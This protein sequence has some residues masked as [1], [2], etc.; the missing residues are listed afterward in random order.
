VG[1]R[2]KQRLTDYVDEVGT[3]GT[4]AALP[5]LYA[6]GERVGADASGIAPEAAAGKE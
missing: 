2:T 1:K 5:L 6:L 3:D 4:N